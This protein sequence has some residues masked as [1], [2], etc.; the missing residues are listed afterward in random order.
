[1]TEGRGVSALLRGPLADIVESNPDILGR[2]N[3]TIQTLKVEVRNEE[4]KF[5]TSPTVIEILGQD[6]NRLKASGIHENIIIVAMPKALPSR[7]ATVSNREKNNTECLSVS[8]GSLSVEG[9]AA[10]DQSFLL[11]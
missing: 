1:M 5:S 2:G 9:K 8:Q 10:L 7:K 4:S 3:N 11:P 6:G